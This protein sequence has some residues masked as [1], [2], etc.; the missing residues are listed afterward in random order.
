MRNSINFTEVVLIYSSQKSAFLCSRCT[1]IW[2][3]EYYLQEY[4]WK[5]KYVLCNSFVL[6]EMHAM[7]LWLLKPCNQILRWSQ[8]SIMLKNTVFQVEFVHFFSRKLTCLLQWKMLFIKSVLK[9]K[10]LNEKHFNMWLVTFPWKIR[11]G[12]KISVLEQK[13]ISWPVL[14]RNSFS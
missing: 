13:N 12:K 1:S 2:M 7:V 5:T 3:I 6:F 10:N 9:N 4:S 14:L 11:K 8:D